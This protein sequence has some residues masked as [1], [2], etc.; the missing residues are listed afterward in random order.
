MSYSYPDFINFCEKES[1]SIRI[2]RDIIWYNQIPVPSILVKKMFFDSDAFIQLYLNHVLSCLLLAISELSNEVDKGYFEQFPSPDIA[3]QES[4]ILEKIWL[5]LQP[6]QLYKDI[7][8]QLTSSLCNYEYELSYQD[9]YQCLSHKGKKYERLFIPNLV[10]DLLEK[11]A[12]KV[13]KF[14]KGKNGD[15]FGN[16]IA[17]ELNIYKAGFS[18]AFSG[19]FNRYLDYKL[20]YYLK[21]DPRLASHGQTSIETIIKIG[22]ITPVDYCNGNYWEPMLSQGGG[23]GAETDFNHPFH[24]LSNDKKSAV[25][26]LALSKEEMLIFSDDKKQTIEEFRFRVSQRLREYSHLLSDS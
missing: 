4:H 26:L 1:S 22:S 2:E 11:S 24:S 6:L 5:N 16:V 12:P 20:D 10:K 13:R 3:N 8:K 25:L 9:F 21:I 15:F 23:I 19:I 17:D 7:E 14:L 18:D